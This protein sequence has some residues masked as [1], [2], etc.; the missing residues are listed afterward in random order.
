MSLF[1]STLY[2]LTK[3]IKS[4]STFLNKLG[5]PFFSLKP[6]KLCRKYLQKGPPVGMNSVGTGGSHLVDVISGS[7]EHHRPNE[8]LRENIGFCHP[9]AENVG[10]VRRILGVILRTDRKAQ[11]HRISPAGTDP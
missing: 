11:G 7:I 4:S 10:A 6:G 3:G 9:P 1:L 8:H 5:K 2:Y